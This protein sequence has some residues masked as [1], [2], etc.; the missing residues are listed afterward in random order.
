V[1]NILPAIIPNFNSAFVLQMFRSIKH[2]KDFEVSLNYESAN[3]LPPGIS[4]T[5]F[6]QYSVAGLSE[7]SEKYGFAF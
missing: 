1:V 5:K 3:E 6:A 7:A 2:N 4:S